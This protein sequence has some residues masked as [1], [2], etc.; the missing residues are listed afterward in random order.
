MGPARARAPTD[1]GRW[2]LPT[3]RIQDHDHIRARF[4]FEFEFE[5]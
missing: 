3:H 5:R 1:G 2:A 4:V